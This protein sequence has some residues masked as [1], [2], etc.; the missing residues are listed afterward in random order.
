MRTGFGVDAGVGDAETLDGA[1][2]H[3]M[4]FDDFGRVFR[5]HAAVPDRLRVDHNGRPMFALIETKRFVDSDVGQAGSLAQLLELRENFVLSIG[6]AGGTGCSLGANIMTDED[7]M[8]VQRQ[9]G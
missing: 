1:A 2:V 7:M 4:L 6:G 9:S 3:Q 5:L 8:I